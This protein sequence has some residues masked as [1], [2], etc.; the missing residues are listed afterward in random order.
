M[1]Y[2]TTI[3]NIKLTCLTGTK[4]KK[5]HA[6]LRALRSVPVQYS[7]IEKTSHYYYARKTPDRQVAF[8]APPFIAPFFAI[9]RPKKLKY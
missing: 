6:Y 3:I 5:A 7:I 1:R 8:P 2:Y 9:D 4:K